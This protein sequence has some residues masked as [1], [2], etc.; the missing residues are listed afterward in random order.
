MF[1]VIPNTLNLKNTAYLPIQLFLICTSIISTALLIYPD[2]I[3]NS[4]V[5][6][7]S[8]NA[9]HGI[10]GFMINNSF[11]SEEIHDS[12]CSQT[13]RPW[14]NHVS[15][16]G[17]VFHFP[18]AVSLF[19]PHAHAVCSQGDAFSFPV[20]RTDVPQVPLWS[21]WQHSLTPAPQS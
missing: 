10:I 3:R 21:S 15:S 19:S 1:E 11:P 6:F 2:K 9:L 20:A 18:K 14:R 4:R 7:C 16:P 12:L 13:G 8:S 5:V 17:L